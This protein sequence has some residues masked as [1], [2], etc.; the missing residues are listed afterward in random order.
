[1]SREVFVM[2]IF[3]LEKAYP[4]KE[5]IKRILNTEFYFD[6]NSWY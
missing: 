3:L 5:K 1:M 2:Y 6:V 4:V